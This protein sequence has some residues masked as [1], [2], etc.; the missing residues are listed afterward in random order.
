MT[1]FSGLQTTFIATAFVFQ[2]VL[3]IHFALRKWNF[4]FAMRYGFI[5]YFLSLPALVVS[6]VLL[7][8]GVSWSFWLSGILYVAWA[9]FGYIVEYVQKIQWRNPIRW[10]IFLPYVV[11]Y[12]A[13]VMFYWWP[14]AEISKALWFVYAVLFVLAMLLNLTS[15]GA[16]STSG[17]FP[18]E[19]G[20]DRR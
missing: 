9:C 7:S 15:H 19:N 4:E 5:V 20:P 6:L 10:S 18:K 17:E 12:L 13:T 8:R 1:G 14:I 3:L 2:I 16:P 11:L